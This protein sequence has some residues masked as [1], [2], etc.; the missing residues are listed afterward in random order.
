M[1][2]KIQ[3]FATG[4]ISRCHLSKPRVCNSKTNPN[5]SWNQYSIY[6][7]GA[8]ED[9]GE[10]IEMYFNSQYPVAVYEG[11]ADEAVDPAKADG[12]IFKGRVMVTQII[13]DDGK[14]RYYLNAVCISEIIGEDGI[15]SNPFKDNPLTVSPFV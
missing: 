10:P 5:E 6:I 11:D 12:A 2:D 13:H 4:E 1:S 8:F 14:I 15:K 3:R 7:E 9:N